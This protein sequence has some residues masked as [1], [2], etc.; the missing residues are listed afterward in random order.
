MINDIMKNQPHEVSELICL[1]CLK[2]AI[3]VYPKRTLLKDLECNCGETGFLIKTGQELQ[4]DECLIC[5]NLEDG[6]CK[7]KLQGNVAYCDYYE[8]K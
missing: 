5:K 7:L 3:H 8:V 2:R 1:K 6:K 4:T